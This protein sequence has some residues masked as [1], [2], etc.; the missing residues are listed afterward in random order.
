MSDEIEALR[1]EMRLIEAEFLAWRRASAA[2]LSRLRVLLPPAADAAL[3]EEFA[4]MIAEGDDAADN[5]ESERY[6]IAT[7]LLRPDRD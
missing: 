4:S 1:I 2:L 6:F 7:E 5:L 3:A